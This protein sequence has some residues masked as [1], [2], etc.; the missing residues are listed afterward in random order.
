M[1]TRSNTDPTRRADIFAARP[2]EAVEALRAPSHRS[3]L[4]G[5]DVVEVVERLGIDF[6]TVPFTIE[7]L[8]LG[9]EVESKYANELTPSMP[10]NLDGDLVEVGTIA[11][12]NLHERLDYY[13]QLTRAHAPGDPTRLLH[14]HSNVGTD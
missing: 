13:T 5:A 11:V 14:A 3:D 4:T 12:A 1:V 7:D 9:L 2:E 6:S 8:R 10:D